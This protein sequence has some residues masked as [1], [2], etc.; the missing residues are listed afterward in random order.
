M[1][2][3]TTRRRASSSCRSAPNPWHSTR[4]NFDCIYDDIFKPA[5]SAVALPEGGRLR[6]VRT[7]KEFYAGSID[8]AMFRT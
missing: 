4:V 2:P 5:I 8:E 6:P 7:D 3:S 1:P